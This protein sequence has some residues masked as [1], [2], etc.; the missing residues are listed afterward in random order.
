MN[1]D[2]GT[3]ARL[4]GEERPSEMQGTLNTLV[5]NDTKQR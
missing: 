5:E 2:P 1:Y 3:G 4:V